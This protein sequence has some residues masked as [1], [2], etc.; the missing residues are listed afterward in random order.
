LTAE[1]LREVLD[2]D[3][4]TG[5]FTW[6]TNVSSTGRFGGT[7][8]CKN[9]AGYVLIRIDRRLYTAHRLAVLHVTGQWPSALVDHRDMDKANNRWGNLR[10]A[11]KGQNGQNKVA[12]QSNN[13]KSGL[14]GVYWSEANQSWGAKVVV[15]RRQHHG[16]FHPTAEAA[17]RAYVEL[18]RQI[19]PYGTL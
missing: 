15:N 11:T 4:D 12:A 19:H 3:K 2:Y 5:L 14:L 18:K 8:G 17:H 16:G 7:A 13:L 6:R 1:R 9:K 10:P